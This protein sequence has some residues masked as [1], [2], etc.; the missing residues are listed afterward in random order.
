MKGKVIV[1]ESPDGCGKATQT[2][3]LYDKL[4]SKGYN[5]MH[6]DY[7]R[8]S[9]PSCLL[10][11]SYL[12]GEFGTN[13]QEISP[14]MASSFYAIDRYISHLV[15]WKEFYDNGG[16][17]IFDRYS[18]SNILHQTSKI[19]DKVEKYKLINWLEQLE[20]ETYSLPRPD[21]VFYLNMPIEQ[22]IKLMENRKNKINGEDKKDIHESDKQH[23][24]DAHENATDI[25]NIYEWTVIDCMDRDKKLKSIDDIH[26][27]IYEL[28]VSYLE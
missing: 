5:V 20:F 8:Y 16:I 25:I 23:L 24:I 22:S 2:K 11:E 13:A 10:V 6:L 19:K 9:M 28:A 15:E 7:P 3:L 12:N 4:K 14:Y 26:E 21:V 17:M 18:S 1:L 27:E